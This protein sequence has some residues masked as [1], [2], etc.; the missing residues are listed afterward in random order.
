VFFMS[1][2]FSQNW[3]TL[4]SMWTFRSSWHFEKLWFLVVPQHGHLY[5]DCFLQL[6]VSTIS[7]NLMLI[8]TTFCHHSFRVYKKCTYVLESTILLLSFPHSMCQKC[9]MLGFG[10]FGVGGCIHAWMIHL[11]HYRPLTCLKNMFWMMPLIF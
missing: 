10:G 3:H 9:N 8:S 7:F 6:L 11:H 1:Q 5:F 4:W 2:T